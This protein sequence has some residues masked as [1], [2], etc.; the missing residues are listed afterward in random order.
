[1]LCS[2]QQICKKNE[3]ILHRGVEVMLSRHVLN[4]N[5]F[6]FETH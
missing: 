4:K 2:T 6:N 1:M 3:D 5:K